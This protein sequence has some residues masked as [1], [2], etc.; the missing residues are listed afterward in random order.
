[1]QSWHAVARPIVLMFTLALAACAGGGRGTTGTLTNAAI[2][3][4]GPAA[5]PTCIDCVNGTVAVPDPVSFGSNPV[6]PQLSISA[7]PSFAN[8]QAAIFPL[9]FTGYQWNGGAWRRLQEEARYSP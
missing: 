1:M 5:T 6:A 8:P 9:L 7:G 4:S 3:G 2:N